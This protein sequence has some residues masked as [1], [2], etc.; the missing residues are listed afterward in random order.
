[1]NNIIIVSSDSSIYI[2]L[3]TTT[4]TRDSKNN[5]KYKYITYTDHVCNDIE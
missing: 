2:D 5:V 1:M 3:I 4:T